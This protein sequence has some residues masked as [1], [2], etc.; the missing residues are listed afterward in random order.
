MII[1]DEKKFIF[2]HMRKTGGKTAKHFLTKAL[3][4]EG[5]KFKM[6]S[7]K[8]L[9]P[10]QVSKNFPQYEDYYKVVFVR[11]PYDRIVSLYHEKDQFVAHLGAR[12]NIKMPFRDWVYACCR[13]N[14]K[15]INKAILERAKKVSQPQYLDIYDEDK[16]LVNHI[17]KFENWKEEFAHICSQIDTANYYTPERDSW[18][19]TSTHLH[20]S[21]YYDEKLLKLVGNRYK[22]DLE[23]FN[24]NFENGKK[25]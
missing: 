20:Y 8:H 19:N 25:E 1:C 23:L 13:E 22:K 12:K 24:Y 9:T 18:V 10:L 15:N 5:I 4:E 6:P 2:F 7:S 16:L 11:N 17:S 3:E 21:N 14:N